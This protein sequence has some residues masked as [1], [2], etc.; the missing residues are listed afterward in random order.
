MILILSIIPYLSISSTQIIDLLQ[1]ILPKELVQIFEAKHSGILTIGIVT[2]LWSVSSGIGAFINSMN[3]A[4][5]TMENRN[6][7]TIKI[8]SVFLTVCLVLAF[9]TMLVLP[10]FG[11]ILLHLLKTHFL[12]PRPIS[13]ILNILRWVISI[14]VIGSTLSVIYYFGANDYDF[15]L[16]SNNNR[17]KAT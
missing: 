2:T 5:E 17:K 7:V 12:I 3:I 8:I 6:Y 4:Y 10:V 13:F 16:R 1:P 11:H 14:V 15:I 9:I